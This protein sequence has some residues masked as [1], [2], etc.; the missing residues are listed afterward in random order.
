M[1]PKGFTTSVLERDQLAF[2]SA[3][4]LV[5]GSLSRSEARMSRVWFSEDSHL[6]PDFN[7]QHTD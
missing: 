3:L 4:L 7:F 2:R 5:T 1:Q 6:L